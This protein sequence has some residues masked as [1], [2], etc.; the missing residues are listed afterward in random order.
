[1]DKSDTNLNTRSGMS[2]LKEFLGGDDRKL[3]SS[4]PVMKIS[5][6]GDFLE[7][8]LSDSRKVGGN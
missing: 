6:G 5:G 7:N 3:R 4:F 2:D 8:F 1:M